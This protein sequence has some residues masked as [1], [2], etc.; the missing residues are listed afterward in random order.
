MKC[1]WSMG[2]GASER[3]E[4]SRALLGLTGSETRSHASS[5]P[6]ELSPARDET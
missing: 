1:I 5:V 2:S 4:S 6:H 3:W